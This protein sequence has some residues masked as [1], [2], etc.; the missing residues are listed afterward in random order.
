MHWEYIMNGEHSFPWS[1]THAQ[2]VFIVLYLSLEKSHG[3]VLMNT[4]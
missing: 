2:L 1:L 4:T 3:L